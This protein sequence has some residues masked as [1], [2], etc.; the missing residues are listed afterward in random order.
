MA[1]LSCSSLCS[2]TWVW[3]LRYSKYVIKHVE[4][5]YSF[6]LL[7]LSRLGHWGCLALSICLRWEN[8]RSHISELSPCLWEIVGSFLYLCQLLSTLSWNCH[9]N[10]CPVPS[11]AAGLKANQ[12]LEVDIPS[13]AVLPICTYSHTGA[14]EG[15]TVAFEILT[16]PV[17]PP[18]MDWM[19]YPVKFT[20]KSYLLNAM[21]LRG[22]AFGEWS[23][24]EDIAESGV[25]KMGSAPL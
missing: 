10:P 16:C 9:N 12:M 1:C 7:S 11:Q 3:F 8:G 4:L 25:P 13:W 14:H 5:M 15:L 2:G 21:V 23:G 18:I 6:L 19:F 24:L 17:F 22:V 20:L